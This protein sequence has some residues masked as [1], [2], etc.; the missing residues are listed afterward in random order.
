MNPCKKIPDASHTLQITTPTAILKGKAFTVAYQ[1]PH[2]RVAIPTGH[3]QF[4]KHASNS[5]LSIVPS[6]VDRIDL[7]IGSPAQK[8]IFIISS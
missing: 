8:D 2:Q 6:Q 5:L 7:D 4:Q 1:L 3:A